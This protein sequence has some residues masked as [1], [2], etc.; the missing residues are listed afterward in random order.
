[1]GSISA[2]GGSLLRGRSC[3]LALQKLARART[4]YVVGDKM[5]AWGV[6][7]VALAHR[8]FLEKART[9]N[10]HNDYTRYTPQR[11]SQT[12]GEKIAAAMCLGFSS[13]M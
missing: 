4:S 12:G 1:V 8:I 2:R 11:R 3:A 6:S 13:F 7:S 9:P 5:W 10:K